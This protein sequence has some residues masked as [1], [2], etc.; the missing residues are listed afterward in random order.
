MSGSR[1]GQEMHKMSL[2]HGVIIKT[3]DAIK[4]IMPPKKWRQ[5]PPG[6]GSNR[7]KMEHM[8]IKRIMM[9][10]I[11]THHASYISHDDVSS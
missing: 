8:N 7:S 11:E 3:K 6:R 1:C 2:A 9:P 10:V 5:K 4:N